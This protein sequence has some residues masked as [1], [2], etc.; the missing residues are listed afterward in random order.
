[1]VERHH[2]INAIIY[3]Y[4]Y[5]NPSYLEIGVWAGDT[6]KHINSLIKD[7][8]DP[9]QYCEC[10]YVNYKMTSDFFFENN[11][12]KKYDVIFIDGLH[13]AHQVSKDIYNSINNLNNGGVII[14]DDVYPH[15]ENEQNA[16]DLNKSGAQTGDV[17]KAV[18]NVLDDLIE[19]S[20]E[21]LFFPNVERGNLAF[22]I[23]KNNDKNITIDS[24]I[25]TM[26]VDGWYKGGDKEWNKYT[27]AKDFN[28][29]LKKI[30][31]F[32]PKLGSL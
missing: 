26:N 8:V 4:G 16:L 5:V 30:T 21:V 6:F 22:K 18:Y 24:T 9:G 20:D 13:T 2:V 29:Y 1:M 19:M 32:I 14:L 17:W 25:P 31:E 12:S 10:N 3:K 7:G 28:N 23:K 15:N 11:I 27:Y